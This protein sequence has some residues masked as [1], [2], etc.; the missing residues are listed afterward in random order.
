MSGTGKNRKKIYNTEIKECK[1]V[2][3]EEA[4]TENKR[5]KKQENQIPLAT[6]NFT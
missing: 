2:G 1:N 4:R 5:Y 6:L 3:K